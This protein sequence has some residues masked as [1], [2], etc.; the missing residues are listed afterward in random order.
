MPYL[1]FAALIEEEL[2]WG[3]TMA[4]FK[5]GLPLKTYSVQLIKCL[6]AAFI[7]R[8]SACTVNDIIDRRMDADVGMYIFLSRGCA[9][10]MIM[11][12][13][14]SQ[15]VP[16]ADLF[17]VVGFLCLLRSSFCS[18]NISSEFRFSILHF[19]NWRKSPFMNALI[20][21]IIHV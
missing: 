14:E 10:L 7:V 18:F 1:C 21:L 16:K 3:L 5:I 2:A 9:L 17:Q 13:M 15:N 12:E 19:R 4:A 8:S 11:Y 20:M 6:I